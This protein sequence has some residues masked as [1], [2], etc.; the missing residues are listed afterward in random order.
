[1]TTKGGVIDL[2]PNLNLTH[3][4]NEEGTDSKCTGAGDVVLLVNPVVFLTRVL[5]RISLC[6][7]FKRDVLEN[8][9]VS[10]FTMNRGRLFW[11]EA[12]DIK[13]SSDQTKTKKNKK[14]E[15]VFAKMF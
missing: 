13:T 15:G 1:M 14:G 11:T 8:L 4:R 12:Q 7:D 6:V 5:A 9:P 2:L 10:L 3:L